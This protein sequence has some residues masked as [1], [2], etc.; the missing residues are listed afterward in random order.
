MLTAMEPLAPPLLSTTMAEPMCS[1][2]PRATAR[3][4]MSS[5]PPGAVETVMRI[6]LLGNPLGSSGFFC[7]ARALPGRPTANDS[8]AST[9]AQT[10]RS[11]AWFMLLSFCGLEAAF[12]IVA[13][14]VVAMGR[15]PFSLL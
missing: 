10:P 14:A 7:C 8:A 13:A 3:V 5:P 2:M 6:G 1:D 4:T 15:R 12:S 9:A 11:E